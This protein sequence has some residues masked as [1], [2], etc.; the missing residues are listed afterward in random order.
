[1]SYHYY[2]NNNEFQTYVDRLK[3]EPREL[4]EAGFQFKFYNELNE[5]ILD[6]WFNIDRRISHLNF[7]PPKFEPRIL[8]S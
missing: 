3:F 4:L 6:F 1:M 7:R 5:A 2:S 8:K